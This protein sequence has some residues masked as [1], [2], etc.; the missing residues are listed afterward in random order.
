MKRQCIVATFCLLAISELAMARVN[1]F[2]CEPEWA[3]LTAEI[4]GDLVSVVSATTGVQDVHHIEARPALIAEVRNADLLVCTGAGLESSWLPVLQR[5]ANNPRVQKGEPGYM[6]AASY[7]RLL[8]RPTRIDRA[9][10]DVHAE[11]NPHIQLDPRNYPVIATELAN[12][13]AETDP[14]HTQDY[15]EGLADFLAR[16]QVALERWNELAL[17]LQ[18]MPVVVHHDS[19]VY[20]DNWLGLKRIATLEPKPGVPPVSSHLAR[21]LQD[22]QQRPARVIIRSSYQNARA[23]E[24]LSQRT[25]IPA[26]ELPATVDGNGAAVDLFALFD[27]ILQQLLS[28]AP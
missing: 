1:V 11:G 6:E 26:I 25:D 16:W 13:L 18:G 21:L 24:W 10:G 14:S 5:R 15:E 22:M 23:S 9:A 8:D 19:W 20:L 28:V 2:T 4:G 17:P 27:N 12:R 3:A 7:V